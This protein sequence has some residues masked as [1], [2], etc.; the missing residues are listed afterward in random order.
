M[1]VFDGEDGIIIDAAEGG[2]AAI[3]GGED[4]GIG[5]GASV[6]FKGAGEEVV[7]GVVLFDIFRGFVQVY[8]S[9]FSEGGVDR[10]LYFLWEVYGGDDAESAAGESGREERQIFFSEV[11]HN[12]PLY[13]ETIWPRNGQW[14]YTVNVCGTYRLVFIF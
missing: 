10:F 2:D 12:Y 6:R 8:F 9:D 13:M 3:D 5:E 4:I 11:R 7:E 14:E 1:L